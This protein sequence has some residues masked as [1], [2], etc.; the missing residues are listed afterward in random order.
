L[1]A[2]ALSEK[3]KRIK[4]NLTSIVAVAAAF[5]GC[6]SIITNSAGNLQ[7]VLDT[8]CVQP[9]VI[10]LIQDTMT[11]NSFIFAAPNLSSGFHNIQIQAVIDAQGDNQ[12]GT[13]TAAALVGKGTLSA[14]SVRLAQDPPFPYVI[15]TQ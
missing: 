6:L 15:Q 1:V 12:N 7:I 13:F 4:K 14:E 11:A 9:E 8:N 5:A 10:G 2:Q 3:E